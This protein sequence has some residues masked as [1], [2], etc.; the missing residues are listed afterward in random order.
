MYFGKLLERI[1][2]S[3]LQQYF[4]T[5]SL[6]AKSQSGYRPFHS[7]ETALLKVTNDILLSLDKGEEVIL[8]LLDFSCA[9]DIIKHDILS[10]HLKLRFGINGQALRWIESYLSRRTHTVVIGN[11]RSSRH[12]I[13]QGVPQGSVLGPIL[14]TI[15]TSP[16][17]S[18]IDT[19]TIHKMFYADDTQLYIAFKRNDVVDVT[20]EISNCVRS[21]KEWSQINGLK[22]NNIKT[23]F[24][25]GSSRHR[26]TNPI[27][28]LNLDGTLVH[29]AKICRN[30]GVAFDKFTLEKFCVTKMSLCIIWVV[31]NR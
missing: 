15:Y 30:L 6:H 5:F 31:Q 25:H 22:L 16:L 10:Q 17:E 1:A 2:A 12:T 8:V 13:S 27:L 24:L 28:T 11:E 29:S 20:T 4:G 18:I 26:L 7:V 21:V 9:F 23:E 14:F 3:Q 19:H